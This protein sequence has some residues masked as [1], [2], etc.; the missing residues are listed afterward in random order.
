MIKAPQGE[1]LK[2]Y[3][4]TFEDYMD[5]ING[6]TSWFSVKANDIAEAEAHATEILDYEEGWANWGNM[7]IEEMK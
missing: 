3:K 6:T 4:I 5:V 1:N 2:T 7:E